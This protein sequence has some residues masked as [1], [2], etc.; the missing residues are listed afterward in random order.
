MI[1][2]SLDVLTVIFRKLAHV[3]DFRPVLLNLE[4]GN[5]EFNG[6]E[7]VEAFSKSVANDIVFLFGTNTSRQFKELIGQLQRHFLNS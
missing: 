1:H 6:R 3:P 4:I 5:G 7:L 2:E